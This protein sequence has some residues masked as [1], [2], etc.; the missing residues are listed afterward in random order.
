LI[1]GLFALIF[2]APSVAT[3]ILQVATVLGALAGGYF[4]LNIF[5]SSSI[6]APQQAAEAAQ[7]AAVVIVPYCLM[8][9]AASCAQERI[10]QTHTKL[11]ASMANSTHIIE[12]GAMRPTI[13]E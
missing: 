13:A 5:L 10:L 4:L 3:V 8:R 7:A 1:G 6:S 2:A 11:L 9:V 12:R